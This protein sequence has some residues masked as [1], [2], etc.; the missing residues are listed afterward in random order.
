[1]MQIDCLNKIAPART[2]G[3]DRTSTLPAMR[4]Q[5]LHGVV[6]VKPETVA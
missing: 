4:R 5:P 6:A 2:G 1:M 3:A